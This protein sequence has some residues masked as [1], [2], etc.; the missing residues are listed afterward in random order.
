MRYQLALCF[1]IAL[2]AC[3]GASDSGRRSVQVWTVSAG[4]ALVI[5][6]DETK[7]G[8]QLFEVQGATRLS[9]GRIVKGNGGSSE[10]RYFSATGDLLNTVGRQGRG[11][12]EFRRIMSMVAA[13]GDSLAVLSADPAILVISPEP[14]IVSKRPVA[15]DHMRFHCRIAESGISI[16]ADGSLLIQ[17]EENRG[18]GGCPPM[19]DGRSRNTDMLARLDPVDFRLDTLGIFPGTERDG[20]RYAAFGRMLAVTSSSDRLFAGDTGGD[21]IAVFSLS[22][23]R[24]ATWRVQLEPRSIP[25]SVRAQKPEPYTRSDGTVITPE[26]YVFDAVYPRFGRL[27]A[28]RLGFLWVMAYPALQEPIGS[29]R[30]KSMYAPLVDAQGA[31]WTILDREGRLAAS[32]RTPP[33]LYVL[34]VGA[35]YLLGLVRNELDVESVHLYRMQRD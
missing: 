18:I 26:P 17:A 7:E 6:E 29:Y 9:D 33:G 3:S 16:V 27:L 21:S 30:L 8:H 31:E 1:A 24:E 32:L 23:T 28:D 15:W 10:I 25:E 14:R 22:G 34:E 12:E 35:D 2:S 5:G 4:P 20:P 19:L 13:A 11:P